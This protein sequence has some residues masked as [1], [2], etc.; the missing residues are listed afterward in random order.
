MHINISLEQSCEKRQFIRSEVSEVFF[1]TI[2]LK[3][4]MKTLNTFLK[5]HLNF[6]LDKAKEQKYE[7][8]MWKIY[9]R[10]T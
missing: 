7:P 3:A 5:K 8:D 4:Y 6:F 10:C 9:E 2:C 1:A